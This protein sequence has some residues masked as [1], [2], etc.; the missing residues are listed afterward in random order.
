MVIARRVGAAD[1]HGRALANGLEALQ[2]LDVLR[3]VARLPRHHY[4]FPSGL[5]SGSGTNW[6]ERFTLRTF[7]FRAISC[8]LP[9][10]ALSWYLRGCRSS[11]RPFSVSSSISAS[12]SEV[13]R[14][15]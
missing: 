14:K 13:Q 3:R 11:L 5:L 9:P 2:H 1:V 8:P 7:S 4:A 6:I 15:A 10:R 12:L